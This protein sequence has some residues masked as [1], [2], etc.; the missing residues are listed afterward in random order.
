VHA[1]TRAQITTLRVL[2]EVFEARKTMAPVPWAEHNPSR[3]ELVKEAAWAVAAVE[4]HDARPIEGRT[5]P[6]HEVIGG[7]GEQCKGAKVEGYITVQ[8]DGRWHC[9]C[10]GRVTDSGV[11]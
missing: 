4:A 2:E 11:E 9:N 8:P 10:C 5:M 1:R 3:E 6:P 7:T